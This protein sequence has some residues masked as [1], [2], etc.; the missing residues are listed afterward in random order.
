MTE[1]PSIEE[2]R[3][4]CELFQ[5]SPFTAYLM[6]RDESDYPT[7]LATGQKLLTQ[8]HNVVRRGDPLSTEQMITDNM[9]RCGLSYQECEL[10]MKL[11]PLFTYPTNAEM[12]AYNTGPWVRDMI[13]KGWSEEQAEQKYIQHYR[14]QLKGFVPR[15]LQNIPW[16]ENGQILRKMHNHKTCCLIAYYMVTRDESYEA[17]LQYS[18]EHWTLL[19]NEQLS[20]SP[21]EKAVIQTGL[22]EDVIRRLMELAS[23][24][25]FDQPTPDEL[26]RCETG[27]WANYMVKYGWDKQ[28]ARQVYIQMYLETL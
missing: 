3:V 2:I 18:H 12:K 21:V 8:E 4:K 14:H 27:P 19:T 11:S 1:L 17:A 16:T 6:I 26:Y 5:T 24:Y 22:P 7:A 15:K 28:F 23:P 9:A 20:L 10:L 13:M 25:P